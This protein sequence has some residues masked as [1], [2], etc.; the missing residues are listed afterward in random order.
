MVE[1]QRLFLTCEIEFSHAI[2]FNRYKRLV[3]YNV[4][5][6]KQVDRY[7]DSYTV[8]HTSGLVPNL[9]KLSK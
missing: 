8:L 1:K 7:F 9:D 5:R 2:T 4:S 6:A 3:W